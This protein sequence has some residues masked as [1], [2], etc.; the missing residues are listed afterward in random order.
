MRDKMVFCQKFLVKCILLDSVLLGLLPQVQSSTFTVYF[1]SNTRSNS[2][3]EYILSCIL[4]SLIRDNIY[5]SGIYLNKK[6]P[7]NK[8]CKT[9]PISPAGLASVYFFLHYKISMC[10]NLGHL[11]CHFSKHIQY[12]WLYWSLKKVQSKDFSSIIRGQQEWQGY[13][14]VNSY[15]G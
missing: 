15:P 4:L 8:Y 12:K 1:L 14:T 11:L 13:V 3:P 5:I 10:T 9:K 2:C 7:L 6:W